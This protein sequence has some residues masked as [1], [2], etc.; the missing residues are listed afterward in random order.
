MAPSSVLENNPL[1]NSAQTL[2]YR[3]KKSRVVG[4]FV[5]SAPSDLNRILFCVDQIIAD[6]LLSPNFFAICCLLI[7]CKKD[8]LKKGTNKE[9]RAS[10]ASSRALSAQYILEHF[11]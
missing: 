9:H 2:E 1:F 8:D 7:H 5:L 6:C 3:E 10:P 4:F 11:H